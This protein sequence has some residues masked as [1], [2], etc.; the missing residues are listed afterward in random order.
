MNLK[1]ILSKS[2]K[3]ELRLI[4]ET[5]AYR[6]EKVIRKKKKGDRAFLYV[7]WKGYSGK[8]NSNVF[9]DEIKSRFTLRYVATA[10]WIFTLTTRFRVSN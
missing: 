2:K 10:A 3:Q 4:V 1:G 9:Q 8:F 7:K 5:K 6:I